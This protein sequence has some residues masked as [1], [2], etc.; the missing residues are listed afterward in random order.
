MKND[1]QSSLLQ[2]LDGAGRLAMFYIAVFDSITELFK[3]ALLVHHVMV[4]D[5]LGS[6]TT[7]EAIEDLV[8]EGRIPAAGTSDGH[9]DFAYA[10]IVFQDLREAIP[11]FNKL[12]VWLREVKLDD[13]VE[14]EKGEFVN[15]I[16]LIVRRVNGLYKTKEY[17]D[18]VAWHLDIAGRSSAGPQTTRW[19]RCQPRR[20]SQQ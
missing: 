13:D 17:L 20:P 4:L 10:A 19:N 9:E 3:Q 15:P 12:L 8:R 5:P 14:I 11:F 7:T 6:L 2:C 16:S 1:R 18:E